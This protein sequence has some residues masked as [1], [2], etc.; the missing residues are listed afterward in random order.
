LGESSVQTEDADD[1]NESDDWDHVFNSGHD[2]SQSAFD[3][4]EE[5]VWSIDSWL[6]WTIAY[7]IY[8]YID[9]FFIN[10]ENAKFIELINSLN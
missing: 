7:F 2:V 1:D 3:A 8:C 9:M 6:P 5:Y 4:T 10:W